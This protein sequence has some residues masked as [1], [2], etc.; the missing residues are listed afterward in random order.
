LRLFVGVFPPDSVR[1]DLRRVL[2]D[3]L[4]LTPIERWH[5]TLVFLGEVAAGRVGEVERALDGVAGS[6]REPRRIAV[7]LAGAGRFGSGPSGALWVGLA[8]DL[9]GLHAL[10]EDV[11]GALAGAGIRGDER[12]F[13]P[14]L[15]VSYARGGAVPEELA[16]YSGPDWIM[17]EF[18][19]V[20]SRHDEGGGYDSLR[21]WSC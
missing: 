9:G 4:K 17:G 18:A 8:G 19:L 3:G 7:R 6:A 20:R 13:R 14:H 12:P 21:Q 5:V 1:A 11:R 10:Q 2:P 16:S 15:T